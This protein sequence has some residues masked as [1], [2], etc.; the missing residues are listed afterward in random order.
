MTGGTH[1]HSQA[2]IT[3]N[4]L[5]DSCTFQADIPCKF[6]AVAW[7]RACSYHHS[8]GKETYLWGGEGKSREDTSCRH[9]LEGMQLGLQLLGSQNRKM[10]LEGNSHGRRRLP[11]ES[12]W[13]ESCCNPAISVF[14]WPKVSCLRASR[15]WERAPMCCALG[16]MDNTAYVTPTV[17]ACHTDRWE[18]TCP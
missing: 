9:S 18:I 17:V 12:H 5:R 3:C 8:E 4:A 1:E 7:K 16:S 2:I 11:G 15:M 6:Q 13:W 10:M 14:A